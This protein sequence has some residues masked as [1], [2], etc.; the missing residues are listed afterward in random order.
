MSPV[1]F[2][3]TLLR[4]RRDRAASRLGAVDFLFAEMAER[5][6]DRL[7][8]TTRRFPF[9]LDIGAHSGFVAR[10]LAGR[11]AIDTLVQMELSAR[12]LAMAPGLRVAGDEEWLPFADNSFDLIVSAGSL[13]WVNDLPGALAQLQ[14]ALKPDGLFLAILPGGN[15]LIELGQAFTDASLS[16]E[17]GASPRVSPFLDVREAGALLQRAGFA[18]PVI[19]TDTLTLSYENAFALM[20]EFRAM[21]E[22]SA[23]V[24][25]PRTFLRRDTLMEMAKIYAE[26]FAGPDGRIPAT[27]ELVTLTGWKPHA[28]Q[29]KPL[30]RGSGKVNLNDLFP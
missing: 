27:I 17:G 12:Q 23:L 22:A 6:C 25:R 15:S 11:G 10:A 7:A 3:R 28:S 2:D 20:N 18:L 21:G 14:R 24:A 16:T 19:D 1:I 8:D 26:R 30:A 29:P 5:L 4:N 13:H 9:A